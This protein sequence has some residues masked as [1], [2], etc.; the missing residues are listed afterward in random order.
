MI[1]VLRKIGYLEFEEKFSTEEA[2]LAFIASQ[3]WKEGYVCRKCGH[4]HYCEGPT[5]FSRRCTRCKHNESATAHTVFHRCRIPLTEAVRMAWLVCNRPKISSY[6][7]SHQFHIR[8]MTCWRLKRKIE[9]CMAE[10]E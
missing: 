1:E 5:P 7:L 9:E 2:C 6:E 3:K 8:Q 10:G 4:T